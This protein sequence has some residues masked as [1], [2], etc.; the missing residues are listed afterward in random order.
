MD[1]FL[2][3][4]PTEFSSERLRLRRYRPEDAPAYYQMLRDNW[5][6]LSE[7]M[8]SNLVGMQNEGD[9]LAVLEWQ[10]AQWQQRN[11]FILGFWEKFSG[12]YLGEV[13]L[14]NADWKLPCLE[15]GYFIVQQHS[16]KGYVTEAARAALRIAF[17]VLQVHRVD[18]QCAADNEKSARVAQ[19]C[20]FTLEGCQR[21]RDRKRDGTRVD[22]LW[23]GLLR[24]EYLA[25]RQA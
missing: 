2:V 12:A 10:I 3:D 7:F 16:G 19:R 18:L 1:P 8:P 23:F 13:Y 5:V 20:G 15:L 22:R 14:A 4:L 11:H 21:Q 25:T 9:V 24:A 17:E 6:H